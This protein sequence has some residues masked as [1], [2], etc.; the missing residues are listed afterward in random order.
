MSSIET[1]KGG[2][3]KFLSKLVEKGQVA[4]TPLFAV[5]ASLTV[6]AVILAVSGIDPGSAYLMIFSEPFGTQFGFT[7]TLTELV[8]L[9]VVAV[10]LLVSFRAGVWN[11]GAQG[12]MLIGALLANVVGYSFGPLPSLIL[13]PMVLLAGCVAGAAWALPPALLKAR[14]GINEVITTLLLNFV[15]INLLRFLIK[16]VLRDVSEHH[17][18]TYPVVETARLPYIFGTSIH[19]G[20]IIAIALVVMI[21]IFMTKIPTGFELRILGQ[22]VKTARYVG[23]PVGRLTILALVISGAT[24]GLAGAIQVSGVMTNIDPVW[25]PTYGIAAVP[26]VFLAKLNAIALLPVSLL[27]AALLVGGDLMHRS[28]GIPVFFVEIILGMM[29]FFFAFSEAISRI[30][31]RA[32]LALWSRT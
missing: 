16:G 28:T 29:L 15:A 17:P 19:I 25:T 21:H 22:S 11:I 23:L 4:F 7:K 2:A 5:L 10:G 8:P 27:F 1:V 24:S 26:L 30:R 20:I 31:L 9:L 13:I 18:L 6:G 3:S 32:R 12:Q 14:L